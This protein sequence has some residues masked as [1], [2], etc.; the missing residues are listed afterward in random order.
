MVWTP[1]SA[2]TDGCSPGGQAQRLAIARAWLRDAPILLFD[3]PTSQVDLA[4]EAAILEALGRLGAERTVI[5]IAH[6]PEAILA[7]DRIIDLAELRAHSSNGAETSGDAPPSSRTPV[8][9]GSQ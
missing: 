7:A 5:M 2:I 9:G 8:R 6:R 1:R 4:G 3:E